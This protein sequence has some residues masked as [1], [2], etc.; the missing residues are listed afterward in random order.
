[1]CAGLLWIW[2]LSFL[3]QT[4]LG[5]YFTNALLVFVLLFNISDST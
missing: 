3:V 5:N 2:T 4:E 1:M